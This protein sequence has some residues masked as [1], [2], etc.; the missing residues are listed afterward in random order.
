[1]RRQLLW[2]LLPFVA[3]F[4]PVF[5]HSEVFADEARVAISGRVVDADS[6][7][8][9]NARVRGIADGD[10]TEATTDG[11]GH[12]VLNVL[13]KRAKQLVIIAE[14]AGGDRLGTFAANRNDPPSAESPIRIELAKCRRLPVHVGDAEGKPAAG[15][16]VGALIHNAPLVSAITA[17]DGSGELKLPADVPLQML[18][19]TKPGEG[20]DYRVVTNPR[21]D[22]PRADWLNQPP[23]RFQLADSKTVKIRLVDAEDMPI[24]GTELFLWLLHKPGEPDSFNLGYTPTEFRALTNDAG[25]AEFR[26]VPSWNVHPLTFWP[27]N[28]LYVRERIAFAL[29]EHSDG[30]L[31]AKLQRL[32]PLAGHVSFA[33]GRPAAGIKV[34]V[35]GN[36]Y[37]FDG[38]H[39]TVTTNDDGSFNLRVAP[40][41]LYMVAVQDKQWAS[42][43]ID[44]L[45][46]KS[47]QV[48]DQL[49]LEL[50]P[51]TRV[52][53]RVT[54]GPDEKSVAGQEMRLRHNGRSLHNLHGVV[55]PNPEGSTKWVQP[56][57]GRFA[58]TDKEGRY[59]FFVGPG[60]FVL[61][62]PSQV[63]PERFEVVDE[64][65]LE[66][67]LA[68]PRPETGPFAGRVV[69]GDPPRPVAGAVIEGK[70]RAFVEGRALR[71]R[72]DE[73]GRFAGERFLHATVLRATNADGDLAG[74]VEIG[75]D[76]AETTISIGPLGAAKARLID[77][78]TRDALPNFEVRW[79]RRVHLGDNKAP[80]EAAW[81]GT[82]M[83]DTA[84]CLEISGLVV[85]QKY[86]LTVSRGDGTYAILQDFTPNA[87]EL[88][89]IGDLAL[90]PPYVPPT[91]EENVNSELN[92]NVAASARYDQALQKAELYNQHLLVIFLKRDTALTESW[93]KLRFD[94]RAV[95]AALDNFQWVTVDAES[96]SAGALAER[97]GLKLDPKALPVWRFCDAS[98]EELL[99]A[100]LPRLTSGDAL[101]QTAILELLAQHAPE[102][103][104]AREL[105]KTALAD[106]A[107]SNRRVIVQ[108]TA[109]WCGPCHLLAQ[110]LERQRSIWEK[111]YIWV[112]VDQ[113]WQGSDEVMNRIKAGKRSGIPWYAILDSSG[114]V[115]ATSDG[116]DGNIG[117]PGAPAS[118]DHFVAMFKSTMQRISE[119]ELAA[120]RE[121]LAHK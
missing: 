55:L 70:Y 29:Q 46:V 21:D 47:D 107:R 33:D 59:E 51:A 27:T 60:K 34:Q 110:Y 93:F 8:A 109:P 85:G 31:T 7:G 3:L 53:G 42:A 22:A 94:D 17:T 99:Q 84:G 105:L 37:K 101:D 5:R 44:G 40:D 28:D 57:I 54:V 25:V 12:F 100:S 108:E 111:D 91:F 52:H 86:S 75:P 102:P 119:Q 96:E 6:Q 15:A 97:L 11:D 66:F 9:P 23:V 113:R 10:L 89:D 58:T 63:E 77:A 69:T 39:E 38:F 26:G 41:L 4:G 19:A 104:D 72:A 24:V 73:Q 48:V 43:A 80:S 65:E 92:A 13:K 87:A 79:F 88:I 45:I 112:R 68:A 90:E 76:V 62:G 67:N 120:L 50:R 95:G 82:A 114:K 81:G 18:Y 35:V 98:G 16:R 117:F 74:I 116:P 1:M 103:L 115:L 32:T 2:L 71:L 121:G 56:G 64:T 14:D 83:T 106:A 36:G 30:Q 78:K 118:I 61:D 20:F 49:R